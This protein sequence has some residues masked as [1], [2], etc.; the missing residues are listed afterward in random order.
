MTLL[1]GATSK[2]LHEMDDEE[3]LKKATAIRM[4][5]FAFAQRIAELTN[6]HKELL[7]ALKAVEGV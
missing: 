1:Y 7:E 4:V 2:G 3:C 5:L 6:E